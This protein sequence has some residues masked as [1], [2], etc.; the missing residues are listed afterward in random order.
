M[1]TVLHH[2]VYKSEKNGHLTGFNSQLQN[3][4]ICY[5]F[6]QLSYL[7]KDS[8]NVT[9]EKYVNFQGA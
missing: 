9:K 8:F 7:N 2:T 3:L 6:G 5:K 1:E 4:K